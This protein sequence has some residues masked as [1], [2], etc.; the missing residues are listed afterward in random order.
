VRTRYVAV[1]LTFIE[2]RGALSCPTILKRAAKA[3][4]PKFDE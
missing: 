4:K 1:A 3:D 2:T